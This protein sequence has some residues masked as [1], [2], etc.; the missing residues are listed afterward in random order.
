MY[1]EKLFFIHKENFFCSSSLAVVIFFFMKSLQTI[2]IR[3]KSVRTPFSSIDFLFFSVFF[4][5]LFL[6]PLFTRYSRYSES[7]RHQ[8]N[9]N[10]KKQNKKKYFTFLSK[11]LHF[12][13]V[14]LLAL[15]TKDDDDATL[16]NL[17]NIL[18]CILLCF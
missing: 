5:F 9:E 15:V 14:M 10:N 16:V 7:Y 8:N 11:C 12:R 1:K 3:I 13:L 4:F 6:F 18:M 2:C 17:I